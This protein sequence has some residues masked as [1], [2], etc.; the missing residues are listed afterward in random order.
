MNQATSL[1]IN[2]QLAMLGP[3]ATPAERAQIWNSAV[4]NEYYV[5]PQEYQLYTGGLGTGVANLPTEISNPALIQAG[6]SQAA[7]AALEQANMKKQIMSVSGTAT[8][9]SEISA[10]VTEAPILPSNYG[11]MNKVSLLER[12]SG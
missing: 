12:T 2:E 9:S 4:E 1:Y 7:A 10:P 11:A 5:S 3:N 6:I 8:N